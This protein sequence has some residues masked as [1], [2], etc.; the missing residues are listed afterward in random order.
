M[1][2][3]LC[4]RLASSFR[5]FALV[6]V[7]AGIHSAN[8]QS[9]VAVSN[10]SEPVYASVQALSI[11]EIVYSRLG[12][13]FTTGDGDYRLDNITV[14]IYDGTNAHNSFSVVLYSDVGGQP[15]T[16]LE[17]LS[18]SNQPTSGEYA[19][20]SAALTA[21]TA[22]TTY[23]WVASVAVGAQN[24]SVGLWETNSTAE[25]GLTGWSI[26]NSL[27]YSGSPTGGWSTGGAT[28]LQFSVYATAV[29]EP[30]TYAGL[31]GLGAL[32]VAFIRRRRKAA[33][34]KATP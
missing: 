16:A 5:S 25:T 4:K 15:G 34:A 11:P 14:R 28:P 27:S 23:W 20:T 18:G 24:R 2:S 12:Q 33:A 19:Y 8:A 32:A 21:L 7:L 1:H 10:L 26:G 29:P 13:S 30:S 17:T 3:I 22:N 6:M 9:T 31:A